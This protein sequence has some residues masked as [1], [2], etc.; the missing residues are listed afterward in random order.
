MPRRLALLLLLGL[1]ASL[2]AVPEPDPDEVEAAR[3]RYAQWRR[4]PE[5]LAQLRQNW[6]SFRAQNAARREQIL[7]LDH[8]LY[9]EPFPEKAQL[10]NALERYTE[11]LER[12]PE[13]DR[14]AVQQAPSKA[15]R[16]TLIQ[17][18]R[19]RE[20]MKGQPKA[21]RAQWDQLQGKA[22]SAFVRQKR[23]EER[24]RHL[25]WQMASRF[26]NE[27]ETRQA[28][29]ARLEDLPPDVQKYVKEVLQPMLE[30][31]EK[32]Q[33]KKA[34]GNWPTYPLTLVE[35]ADRHPPALPG[36]NGPRTIAELPDFVQARIKTKGGGVPKL[37][38]KAEGHW[39]DFAMAVTEFVEKRA[40]VPFPYEFWPHSYNGLQPAMQK[41]VDETLKPV[42][43]SDEKLTLLHCAPKWPDYPQCIQK[44]ARAHHLQPPWF[45][46]PAARWEPAKYRLHKEG[47]VQGYPELPPVLLRDFALYRLDAEE[48]A[49]LKLSPSDPKSWQRLT[50]AYFQQRQHD[51]ARQREREQKAAP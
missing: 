13:K 7:T 28:L 31:A 41:F 16:L 11:W 37:L 1:T 47:R 50:E 25:A 29:P 22:R 3:R 15:A 34:E 38:A 18:L 45:T 32:D 20:W 51:L 36:A 24:Q 19:D 21:I 48:L 44:L 39:P 9:L 17:E 2:W 8:E 23:Q 10:W 14:Q 26:W 35:I 5:Q 33:L 27:L 49:R 6:Q 30:Q 12:L 40:A 4:H 43:T 46:L 42:L